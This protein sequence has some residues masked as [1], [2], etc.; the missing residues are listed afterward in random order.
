MLS[1]SSG[2]VK[3]VLSVLLFPLFFQ[4]SFIS[5]VWGTEDQLWLMLG[6]RLFLLLP[7]FAILLGCW[8]SIASL[9]TVLIR[10]K[11]IEFLTLLLVTWWDLGKSIVYFWGGI[12]KFALNLSAALVGLLKIVS[13]GILSI[14]QEIIFMPF[15]LVRNLSQNL[16]SSPVPWIA[17]YLTLFW[18][19]IE[20]LI[21]TYVTTPLVIDVFSN[22]TGEQLHPYFIR[23]PLFI[24]LL[25][26][27][28]GSYAVLSTFVTAVKS[29]NI[30]SILG[31][32][33]IETVALF[34]EVVFLYREFVDSL[35]PWFAQY[36]EN[37]ELGI[38]GTLAIACFAWFGVRSLSWFLFAAHGTPLLLQVIQGKGIQLFRGGDVPKIRLVSI[39]PEFV[40]K[41]KEESSW[42]MTKGE[43][44]LASLMLPPLQVLASGI[45]FCT[46]LL[47]G[48]HLFELPFNNVGA[49]NDTRTLMDNIFRR[50]SRKKVAEKVSERVAE[51]TPE[52]IE[53][54]E[55]IP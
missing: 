52:S 48:S 12:I 7:V 22:I 14:I 32:G 43:E 10:Q 11:R 4:E 44:L 19:I 33:V 5:F 31:I 50:G 18:C 2:M 34:V 37:F 39:S 28:M 24:F 49:I 8:V 3:I 1:G 47:S 9:T 42:I 25:F 13:L 21:F 53:E 40:N 20:A 30:S 54:K 36:S 46:L 45:N 6:K 17:V 16:L 29:K 26:I 51:K 27:I 23:I 15:R 55:L 35:V 41:I 38:F